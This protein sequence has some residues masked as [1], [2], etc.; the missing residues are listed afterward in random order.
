[1]GAAAAVVEVAVVAVVVVVA[2]ITYRSIKRCHM[3]P[4]IP[5]T[6]PVPSLYPALP[7]KTKH[8]FY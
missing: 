2:I 6:V 3:N 5:H 8:H 4:T 7:L 1:M